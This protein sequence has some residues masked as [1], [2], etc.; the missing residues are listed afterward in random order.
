MNLQSV[1]MYA[2]RSLSGSFANDK[3]NAD[4]ADDQS[5]CQME[6]RTINAESPLINENSRYNT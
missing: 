5:D 3:R 2:R 1:S 4:D 6:S